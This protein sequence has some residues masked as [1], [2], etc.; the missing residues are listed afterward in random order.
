MKSRISF[1]DKTVFRKDLARFA[2]V[3][4]LYL[5]GGLLTALSIL[6]NGSFAVRELTRSLNGLAVANLIYAA[7]CAQMLFGDLFNSKLCNALHAL[8]LRRETWFGSHVMAGVAFSLAPNLI[9][10]LCFLPMLGKGWFLAFVWLLGMTL[11]FLFFFGLAALSA[12]LSGNRVGMAAL[13]GL[14]NFFALILY[15]FINT[16]YAPLLV[17]LDIR[18]EN[19]MRFCPTGWIIGWM[20]DLADFRYYSGWETRYEFIGLTAGW[21]YLALLAVL[22][23]AAL[24]LAVLLYRRRKLESA[25][26]LLAFKPLEPVFAVI[27]T[28]TCGAV[29]QLTGDIFEGQASYIYLIAGILVGWFVSRMLLERRV[30]VFRKGTF[31]GCAAVVAAMGLTLL[32]TWLDPLGLTRWVPD[33]QK[34]ASVTLVDTF[35][36]NERYEYSQ[37]IK[38]ENP[39]LIADVIQAHE[40]LIREGLP[41]WDRYTAPVTLI[42]QMKDGRQIRRHYYYTTGGEA[43]QILDGMFSAPAYVL[44]YEDRQ[45]FLDSVQTVE[46]DW[47]YAV[48]GADARA[49]VVAICADCEAGTMNQNRSHYNYIA[50]LRIDCGEQEVY[51]DLFEDCRN[52]VAWLEEN[53]PEWGGWMEKE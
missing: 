40:A 14:M 28:L 9:L 22:G 6:P 45:Q 5:I 37:A 1:F 24:A 30:R 46:V 13:Y 32:L 52:A 10:S 15:W 12:I 21:W 7:V 41:E 51:V 8:P 23:L 27:A 29:F 35:D 17:G 43:A 25:G 2:P 36:Y 19:F 34:V 31:F 16:F 39:E 53:L 50:S 49:F 26:D 42:Y 33:A 11:Q 44:G 3:W 20:G 18:P 38:L 4:G 48:N 47:E